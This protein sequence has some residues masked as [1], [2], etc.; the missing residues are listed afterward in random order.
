VSG[1]QQSNTTLSAIAAK[2]DQLI[3]ATAEV[4][5]QNSNATQKE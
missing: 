3:A 1:L 5:N 4:A 2:L